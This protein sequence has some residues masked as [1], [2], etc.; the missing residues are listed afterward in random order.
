MDRTRRDVLR[1]LGGIGAALA[2]KRARPQG[3]KARMLERPIPASGEKLPVIGL[4]TWQVFDARADA[5]ARAPLRETL[6]A[7]AKGGA[8]LVDSSPMY[9][10]AESVVGDLAA[11]LGIVKQLFFATKVYTTGREAGLAQMEASM[12]RMR[13]QRMDLMQVHNLVDVAEHVKTLADWK[14]KGRVR[15][16]GITHYRAGAYGEVERWLKAA[17]WDFLQINYSLG[18][19]E[20]AERLLPLA[21]E[22]RVAVIANRP[23]AEGALFA[24]VRGKPLPSWAAEIGAASWA[25]FFL[26]WILGHPAVTCAIPGTGRP[27]HMADNLGAGFG[28]LPDEPMRRR[29][30]AHLDAL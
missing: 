2:M 18:E 28:A 16:T 1:A 23:F 3:A 8:R 7:F 15:Y 5:A 30:A 6:A 12:Q 20:A 11:E 26:K 13:V 29:M 17:P 14:A 10:A 21:R 24:R 4:G 27:D 9:G 22:R 19:R 25:Q